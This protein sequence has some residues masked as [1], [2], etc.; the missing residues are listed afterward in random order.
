[1]IFLNLSPKVTIYSGY[2]IDRCILIFHAYFVVTILYQDSEY[3]QN[4]LALSI[5][6]SAI[7]MY[8]HFIRCFMLRFS[9]Q[10]FY[11]N[12]CGMLM[13]ILI[14]R[15]ILSYSRFPG[16]KHIYLFKTSMSTWCFSDIRVC[17]QIHCILLGH[18]HYSLERKTFV[19]L[20]YSYCS[21]LFQTLFKTLI[22][23]DLI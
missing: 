3:S 23:L 17:M 22:S 9:Q 8:S 16:F 1:M 10:N 13:S 6:S 11:H 2:L 20:F 12:R 18:F 5:R 7:L 21:F 15:N 14:C 19:L 4:D